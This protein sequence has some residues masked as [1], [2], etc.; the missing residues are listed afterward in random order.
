MRGLR[1]LIEVETTE[2]EPGRLGNKKKYGFIDAA[3][4]LVIGPRFDD[5]FQFRHGL[6]AVT[7]AEGR[8]YI[9]KAGNCV[10]KP[11]R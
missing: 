4:R 2:P 10:W 9:D 8:G 11:T 6:A 1:A 3:G 5:A 7:T